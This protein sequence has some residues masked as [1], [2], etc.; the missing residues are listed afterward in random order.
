MKTIPFAFRKKLIKQL[1][2]DSVIDQSDFSED[3]FEGNDF[4][5]LFSDEP[6]LIGVAG[7]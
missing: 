1:K 5:M 6:L 7:V 3:E 2:K 4:D